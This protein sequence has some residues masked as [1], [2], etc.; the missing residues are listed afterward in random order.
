MQ[1]SL[2]TTA[3]E[4]IGWL[5]LALLLGAGAAQ[6]ARA[7]PQC[8]TMAEARAAF[9]R[10]HI[11][12][13]TPK[14]CWD[15]SPKRREVQPAAE[16]AAEPVAEAKQSVAEV[17]RPVVEKK[18]INDPPPAATKTNIGA[19]VEKLVNALSLRWF[20][21]EQPPA[22]KPNPVV[23]Q[24]P[25]VPEKAKVDIVD[26]HVYNILDQ[27]ADR[28]QAKQDNNQRLILAISFVLAVGAAAGAASLLFNR[29]GTWA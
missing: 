7:T 21:V 25:V 12:W 24:A 20:L 2:R 9:P 5:V 3:I 19:R 10:A 1:P 8:M 18:P 15:D 22:P 17:T 27:Q 14:H 29:Q 28:L 26:A 6:S 11:Y 16:K 4:F 13:H 23:Q